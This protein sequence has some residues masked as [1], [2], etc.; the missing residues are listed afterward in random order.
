MV[1]VS[2]GWSFPEHGGPDGGPPIRIDFSTNAHPLGPNAYVRDRVEHT[3]RSR[4]PDPRYTELRESLGAF[5]DVESKRV[6]IGGSASELIWRIT[7]CW[8]ETDGAAVAA[9]QRTFG[10]YLRAA[11]A[12]NVPVAPDHPTGPTMGPMLYWCCNPDNPTGAI[13]DEELGSLIREGARAD[14]KAP[15]VIVA[16]LA[17]EPFRALLEGDAPTPRAKHRAW[18]DRVLQLW[19]PNK[20]HGLTGIR[21]AYLILPV[22]QIARMD[23]AALNRLAPSWVLGADGEALLEAHTRPE[24]SAFLRETAPILRSWKRHQERILV[25]AGWQAQASPLHYGLWKPPID[26]ADVEGWIAMLRSRDIKVRDARSFGR[27]GWVRLVCRKPE[28]VQELVHWADSL[29]I[30]P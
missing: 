30:R 11:L 20:L 29:R 12:L 24:A 28:E 16:D 9:H 19:S 2:S 17:Y 18:L 4:Y 26:P 21:G 25:D 1:A 5:H 15:N 10:E 13:R 14:E 23:A 22:T 27:P 8:S 7:R 3:D 6:V